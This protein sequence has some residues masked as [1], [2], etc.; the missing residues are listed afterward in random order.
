MSDDDISQPPQHAPWAGRIDHDY[1][2]KFNRDPAAYAKVDASVAG[3]AKSADDTLAN[4]P[5][6]I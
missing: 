5:N 3:V 4:R 2:K 1:E 6:P